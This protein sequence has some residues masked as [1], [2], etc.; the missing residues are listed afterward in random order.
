MGAGMEEINEAYA[1]KDLTM[2]YSLFTHGTALI[3]ETPDTLLDYRKYGLGTQI[4]FHP[5]TPQAHQ[6]IPVWDEQGPGSWFHISLPST[7]TTF[8]RQNPHLDSI[9][10]LFKTEHCRISDVHVYDGVQIVQQ[11]QFTAPGELLKGSFLDV[12]DSE[13]IDPS[14]LSPSSK[15]YR[16]TIRIARPHRVFAVISISFYACAFFEDFNVRGRTRDPEF[17][18]PFPPALLTV[19]GAGGQFLVEDSARHVGPWHTQV[20]GKYDG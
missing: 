2:Q 16:N 9:T 10:L 6:G 11:F 20:E 3:V 15:S 1:R 12:R 19:S 14:A 4:T 13:D 7:L 17:D 18:G 8:G 5:P